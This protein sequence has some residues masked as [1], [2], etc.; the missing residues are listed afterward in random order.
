MT[1]MH[2][3]HDSRMASK[4]PSVHLV[5]GDLVRRLG[6]ARRRLRYWQTVSPSNTRKSRGEGYELAK[7]DVERLT[8]LLY[9]N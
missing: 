4:R 3:A 7:A 8:Q 9:G 2:A 6:N 1:Q 5:S